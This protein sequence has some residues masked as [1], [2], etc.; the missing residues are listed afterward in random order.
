VADYQI[1]TSLSLLMTVDEPRPS[2]EARPGGHFALR[3]VPEHPGRAAGVVP[4]E[5]LDQAGLNPAHKGAD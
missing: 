2:L 1:A 4:Q 3:F 5:W